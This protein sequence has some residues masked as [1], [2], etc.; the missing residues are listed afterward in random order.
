MQDLGA[1]ELKYSNQR[2]CKDVEKIS[3]DERGVSGENVDLSFTCH[4]FPICV[5]KNW[6]FAY[7]FLI[8]FTYFRI[9]VVFYKD[10]AYFVL[11][12]HSFTALLP[13]L[14]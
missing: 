2:D 4:Y 5:L 13:V 7:Y 14:E 6:S 10:L 12:I 3:E 1:K 9:I 8:L 11:L